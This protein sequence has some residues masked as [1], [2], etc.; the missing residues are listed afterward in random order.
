LGCRRQR[1]QG[2]AYRRS[3][4]F[5]ALC[6]FSLFQSHIGLADRINSH[7]AFFLAADLSAFLV[8]KA[9]HP[10]C[11]EGLAFAWVLLLPF[12]EPVSLEPVN[13]LGNKSFTN[14]QTAFGLSS[15]TL[16]LVGAQMPGQIQ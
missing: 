15:P 6:C 5:D 10:I 11:V 1:N 13:G 8:S 7:P 2:A 9:A 4:H 12:S 3:N 16:P 14:S